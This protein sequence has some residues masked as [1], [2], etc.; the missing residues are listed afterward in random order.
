M[1]QK[2]E[3]M[4]KLLYNVTVKVE[5]GSVEEWKDYM[6]S[7]HILDVMNTGCFE[8]FRFTRLMYLDEQ[9]GITFAIQY[10]APNAEAF[11]KYQMQY[12]AGLQKEA[13]EKFGDKALAFRTVM[14]IIHESK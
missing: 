9:D 2:H 1:T 5:H 13:H 14:E 6:I 8:D 12:A 4:A 10:I 11:E 7:Y 3:K